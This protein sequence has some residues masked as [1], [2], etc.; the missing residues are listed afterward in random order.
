MS[1][2]NVPVKTPIKTPISTNTSIT[3]PSSTTNNTL[4][5][6]I[7]DNVKNK[8]T[9]RL[10]NL[11]Y[12]LMIAVPILLLLF[13]LLYNYN[14]NSRSANAISNMNYKKQLNNTPLQQCYQQ[15]IKYQF[16]LCDY[17]ISSSYMTPCVGNQHYDYVSN[18]MIAEVL[19][20]GARYIQ[21]PICEADVSL[22][23]LPVVGTAEYGNRVIT[24]LNTLDIQSVLKTING[25]AFTLNNKTTNY[26]LI[27]HLIL[28]TTNKYTLNFLADSI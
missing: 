28:N 25:N 17:Y 27:I 9:N 22:R 8:L 16:K 6:D 19:Q 5:D 23:S 21:I 20:S 18:D 4:V 14:F 24:S 3:T 15:D 10:S 13:Y 1:T 2:I 7:V 26:P 11:K 12:L